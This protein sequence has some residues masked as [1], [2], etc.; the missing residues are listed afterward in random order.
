MQFTAVAWKAVQPIT[1]EKCFR[2]AGI[3]QD[4]GNEVNIAESIEEADVFE[5]PLEWSNVHGTAGL[6]FEH[7]VEWDNNLAVCAFKNDEAILAEITMTEA[8]G[9]S[10]DSVSDQE[11]PA[12]LPTFA[13]AIS[14]FEIVKR[15]VYS[16]NIGEVDSNAFLECERLL[17]HTAAISARQSKITEYFKNA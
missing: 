11:E 5:E 14:A 6:T 16:K 15:F 2:K 3:N 7:F 17:Y 4:L 8:E 12:A 13:Q 1:I 9:S 10:E